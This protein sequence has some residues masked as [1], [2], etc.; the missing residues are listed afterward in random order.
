MQKLKITFTATTKW[1]K[2]RREWK[3]GAGDAFSGTWCIEQ[4]NSQDEV[5]TI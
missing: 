1:E 3:A 4:K 2:D 5:V